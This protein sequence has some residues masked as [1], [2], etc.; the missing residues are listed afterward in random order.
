MST[1]TLITVIAI[2]LLLVM[3]VGFGAYVVGKRVADREARLAEI[4]RQVADLKQ[5]NSV[6]R[7]QLS[8][9]DEQTQ[10]G[11][12]AANQ[13]RAQADTP[14]KAVEALRTDTGL[15]LSVVQPIGDNG[16]PLPDAPSVVNFPMTDVFKFLDYTTAKNVCDVQLNG[17]NAK[18]ANLTK[19]VANAE[20]AQ[21]KQEQATKIEAKKHGFWGKAKWFVIGAGGG[22]LTGYL[23]HR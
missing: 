23:V 17:C 18:I 12:T 3:V 4:N 2:S 6:L 10:R 14:Q 16:K 19:Q 9:I 11:V 22:A 20:Q 21:K 5:A 1:R 15:D 13:R 7:S 8:A